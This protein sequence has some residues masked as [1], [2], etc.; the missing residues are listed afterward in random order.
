MRNLELVQAH[1]LFTFMG[2]LADGPGG[3]LQQRL[4]E[5]KLGR[6]AKVSARAG[7]SVGSGLLCPSRSKHLCARSHR[8]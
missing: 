6:R 5:R 7:A 4:A 8:G 3:I 2:R 1:N